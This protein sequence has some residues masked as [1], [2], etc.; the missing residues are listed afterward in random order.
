MINE[1]IASIFGKRHKQLDGI[2][3]YMFKDLIPKSVMIEVTLTQEFTKAFTSG[4]SRSHKNLAFTEKSELTS[5]EL[6]SFKKYTHLQKNIELGE[7]SKKTEEENN[8][9]TN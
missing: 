6:E 4:P 3:Y 7:I 5:D 1:F 9:V 2:D 8:K